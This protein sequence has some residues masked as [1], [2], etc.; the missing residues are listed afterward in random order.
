[1][2]L[3]ARQ[4]SEQDALELVQTFLRT[5]FS[6]EPRHLRRI[7]QMSRYEDVGRKAQH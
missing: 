3:G 7:E 5:P 1:M 2:A 4:H 6:G